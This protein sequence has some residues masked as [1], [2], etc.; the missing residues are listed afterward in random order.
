MLSVTWDRFSL[1][2]PLFS[3]KKNDHH[4]ITEILLKVVLNILTLTPS[5]WI[6]YRSSLFSR[7]FLSKDNIYATVMQLLSTCE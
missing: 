2:P 4:D 3:T 7:N 5:K 1:N 6:T